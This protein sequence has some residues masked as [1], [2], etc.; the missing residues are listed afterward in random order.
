MRRCSA[1]RGVVTAEWRRRRERIGR[2]QGAVPQR[3]SDEVYVRIE[4]MAPR[5]INY[6]VNKRGRI[7]VR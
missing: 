5:I 1:A 3:V 2:G 4:C 6:D 7:N